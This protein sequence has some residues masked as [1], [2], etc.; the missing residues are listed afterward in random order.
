MAYGDYEDSRPRHEQIAADLRAEIM[1]GDLPA[2]TELDSL[3][4]YA[5]GR[6]HVSIPTMQRALGLLRAEG[7][8]EVG[9][10]KRTKVRQQPPIKIGATA[11]LP[12]GGNTGYRYGKLSVS[13]ARPPADAS[14]AL[15]LDE[16]ELA[17]CRH[18]L[19]FHRDVP[20]EASWAYYRLSL[21]AGTELEVPKLL[22]DGTPRVFADLGLPYA[23][24]EDV[25]SWRAPTE[26]EA[27]LLVMPANVPIL[28]TLRTIRDADG[29]PT[30]VSVLIKPGHLYEMT[31]QNV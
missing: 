21:A 28:R 20:A 22:K 27:S 12:I 26:A 10:G 5:T 7:F 19:L 6:F 25:L 15:G 11:W 30:E 29:V 13:H 3:E 2:G 1:S 14:V 18:R 8:V 16:G 24:P 4:K 17:L 31:Y 23:D 9:Q